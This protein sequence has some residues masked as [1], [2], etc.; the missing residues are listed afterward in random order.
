MEK[1]GTLTWIAGLKAKVC[2][3]AYMSEKYQKQDQ[4]F[5]DASLEFLSVNEQ[6]ELFSYFWMLL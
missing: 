2:L 3:N 6:T 4:A 1:V 5:H